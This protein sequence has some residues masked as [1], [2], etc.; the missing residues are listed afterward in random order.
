M[1]EVCLLVLPEKDGLILLEGLER[2]ELLLSDLML[3]LSLLVV[4]L[5]V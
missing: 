4:V 3:C 2:L 1:L 5:V